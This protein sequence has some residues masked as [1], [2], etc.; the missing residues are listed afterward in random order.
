M[1]INSRSRRGSR[2]G[3][4]GKKREEKERR[5]CIKE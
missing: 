3:R 4:G 5:D 1:G 2:R